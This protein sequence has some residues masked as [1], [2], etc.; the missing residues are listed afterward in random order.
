MNKAK[1]SRIYEIEVNLKKR[2]YIELTADEFNSFPSHY[3]AIKHA[4]KIALDKYNYELLEQ[5]NLPDVK[6]ITEVIDNV[7]K[8]HNQTAKV[9][10]EAQLFA[11]FEEGVMSSSP[12][13]NPDVYDYDPDAMMPKMKEHFKLFL[14][15]P[16]AQPFLNL[17]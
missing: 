10:T 11:A 6:T 13:F 3:K 9:Y 15:T 17:N 4:E 14:E 7:E 2:Y 8:Y 1:Q 12:E 16:E 5:G